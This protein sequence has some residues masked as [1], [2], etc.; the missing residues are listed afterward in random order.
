MTS[1]SMELR[2]DVGRAFDSQ[3]TEYDEVFT[4]STIGRAQR[5][6]VWERAAS[7][8]ARGSHILELNCGTGEDALFLARQGISVFGC[9]ASEKMISVANRRRATE[10]SPLPVRFEVLPTEHIGDARIFGPFDGVLSNFSG[11]NCVADLGAI[12][13]HLAAMV[14]P[15]GRLLVCLSSRVCLWEIAWFLVHGKGRRAFRRFNGRTTASLG[16]IAV[17]VRYPTVRALRKLLSPSFILRSWSGIGI[18]VPPSYLEHMARCYPKAVER[19]GK[20]D[21][22]ISDWPIFRALGDH[23]LLSFERVIS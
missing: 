2:H 4:R 8:F 20:V 18:T 17:N 3:A 19:L 13:Q 9:D 6:A 5:N 10:G 1:A 14:E 23:T 22:A 16:K 21:A 15:G 11:L 7:L 12:A